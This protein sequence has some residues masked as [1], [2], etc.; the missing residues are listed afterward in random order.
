[1]KV[2]VI[3]N[4]SYSQVIG[5]TA[6]PASQLRKLLSYE[7]DPQSTYFAGGFSRK[8]YLIDKAGNFPTGLYHRV[9]DYLDK[10]QIEYIV[11]DKRRL[12]T[13]S[14]PGLRAKFEVIPYYDQLAAAQAAGRARRGIISMPTGSGKSLV[15]ALIIA[16]LKCKTLVVVPS[17]E[18]KV[19]LQADLTRI[20]GV[21]DKIKVLNIDSPELQDASGYDVLLIDEGHHTAAKT[22]QELNKK[23]W[24][25]IYW[26]FFLT[27][28]PFRN[29]AHETLLFE[30]IAG[31][32]IY[33]LTYKDAVA[34]G[35]IVP[36]E[37]YYYEVP[38]SNTEG[39]TWRQVY[40]ELVVNNAARN[41]L[42]AFLLLTLN[43]SETP[44]LCLVKEVH[45]GELLSAITGL[46]FVHGV[47][48]DS[49]KYISMFNKG[50]IKALIGT[51]GIL[52][53]GVD[54]KPA[55]Y[56]LIAGLGKAKSAFMQKVGRAVRRYKDKETAKVIIFKDLS[57]KW[58]LS[59]FNA[60]KKILLDEY[61]V[62]VLKLP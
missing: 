48:E 27:A 2:T 62:K 50:E 5:L 36:V 20:F 58:T 28:T 31:Q 8:K 54:T 9:V 34:L 1:M 46:P 40:S 16:H 49:R 7:S 19:Q 24:N 15:I 51:E 41:E 39:H 17:L 3:I 57:H 44:T 23:V 56:V 21:T 59:H 14:A 10:A 29:Q 6:T 32:V 60:Q 33:E 4:N 47:D 26:R 42:I 45:H 12:P 22:Y 61:G 25:G 30:A 11:D 37:P 38:K 35:Y 53:E 55:E 18:I 52:G 43:A 13:R